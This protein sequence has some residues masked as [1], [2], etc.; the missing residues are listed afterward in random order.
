VTQ[1]TEKDAAKDTGDS[2]PK[3]K[4]TYH[5]ARDDAAGSGELIERNVSKT[6]HKV[7]DSS[8]GS[9]LRGFFWGK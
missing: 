9:I 8:F 4:E 3:V 1:Y 5:K 2:V 7:D 6:S